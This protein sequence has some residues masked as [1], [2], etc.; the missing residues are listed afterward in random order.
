MEKYP[1]IG[2][3][4][5][6]MMNLYERDKIDN[7]GCFIDYLGY[8]HKMN[9]IITK[10]IYNISYAETAIVLVR[11]KLIREL[12]LREKPFDPDYFV[13]WYDI[14]FSWVILLSGYKISFVPYSIVY[15]ERRLTASS[16]KLPYKNIFV[17]NRNRFI[18]LLKNYSLCTLILLL[19]YLIFLEVAKIIVLLKINASHS[20][21]TIHSIFWVLMN[22]KSIFIKR[23][24]VQSYI[25]KVP[26]SYIL[27][28]FLRPNIIRLYRDFHKNY[29]RKI[30]IN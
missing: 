4:Q 5:P 19:P 13:H 6:L 22:L 7:A 28:R 12:P 25:R 9:N 24:I 23:S 1:G 20:L 14:D 8:P 16:G 17:N 2:A 27:K 11:T 30:S 29:G 15:H 3:A 26:D 21:A 18:T 10:K